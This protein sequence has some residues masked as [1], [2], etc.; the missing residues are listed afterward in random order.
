MDGRV[1][2]FQLL[3]F[4]A[5]KLFRPLTRSLICPNILLQP[6]LA[7]PGFAL[8]GSNPIQR[9]PRAT[10]WHYSLRKREFLCHPLSCNLGVSEVE[11]MVS[12]K[13]FETPKQL[14]SGWSGSH[15]FSE[16]LSL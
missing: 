3:S 1:D 11:G 4:S 7:A 13:A 12:A 5:S 15:S 9:I 10:P 2:I 6:Y 8:S 16:H 14:C